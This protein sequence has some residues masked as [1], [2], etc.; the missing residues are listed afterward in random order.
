MPL[1]QSRLIF[2]LA[3]RSFKDTH[4]N[5]TLSSRTSTNLVPDGQ[6]IEKGHDVFIEEG[7][8]RF[9]RVIRNDTIVATQVART[10]AFDLHLNFLHQGAPSTGPVNNAMRGI[11][12]ERLSGL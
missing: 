5:I 1:N 6:P 2:R 10:N 7:K 11:E 9:A 8:P 3:V 12:M 4:T